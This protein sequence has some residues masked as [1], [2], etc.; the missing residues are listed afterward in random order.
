MHIASDAVPHGSLAD[1]EVVNWDVNQLHAE[2]NRAH[3]EKSD[4]RRVEHTEEF[5]S[6]A[7]LKVAQ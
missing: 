2:T 4:P 1:Q 7:G 5:Y 3:D 6:T